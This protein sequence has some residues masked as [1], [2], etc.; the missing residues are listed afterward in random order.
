M[1][2][3]ESIIVP[4]PKKQKAR[5]PIDFRPI[6]TMISCEKL[7]EKT[8]KDQLVNFVESN[9]LLSHCQS[10][11][12]EKFSCES[13]LNLIM[14]KWRERIDRD[15]WVV[16]VFLD[17]KR[18]FETID[19]EILLGKLFMMGIRDNELNWFRSYLCRRTQRTRVGD[20]MSEEV[21]NYLGVPQGSILGAFLFII[22][23]ND[24]QS[25]M[26]H[27]SIN[28]FAD[29]TLIYIC[30]TDLNELIKNVN[31]D[32][33]NL[34]DYL[35]LNK[36]KLNMEKTKTMI[37]GKKICGEISEKIVI[38]NVI[39]D[40]VSSYK[41]L[42]ITVDS[43]LNF[44]EHVDNLCKKVAKK[45]GVLARTRRNLNYLSSVN[46]YKT[47]IAPH[48]D[49]CSSI[50]FM[51]G[52]E[53]FSRMQKLQNRAMRVILKVNRYSKISEMLNTLHFMNVRQRI[54]YNCLILIFKIKH[55]LMPRY[56]N[57]IVSL[58]GQ[59]HDYPVRNRDDF[60]LP[61]MNK[62]RSQ[63]SLFYKGLKAFNELPN[64]IK[65]VETLG[66][67]K[68]RLCKYVKENDI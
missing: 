44:K 40:S 30:G 6:N 10:G 19:R 61:F 16:V 54:V 3:R 23:I 2:V 25:I 32:L 50:L 67:F 41:Y 17:F 48:F 8:V 31:S 60:H 46:I 51:C 47:I 12:R 5:N 65:N 35:C 13:A 18:A 49:Y 63:Q 57:D 55:N 68:E 24:I 66:L 11:Y 53:E 58:V 62:V 26:H 9:D 59:H 34:F 7:L 4:V 15:E 64:V 45:V 1:N 43:K 56:L 20:S 28:L 42:G 36:L 27:C 52:K 37:I 38:D 33:V 14:N 22:Y 39:V 21:E 29:D